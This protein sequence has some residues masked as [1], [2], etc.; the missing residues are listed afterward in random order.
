YTVVLCFM[1][2]KSHSQSLTVGFDLPS[3]VCVGERVAIQNTTNNAVQNTWEF[4]VENMIATPALSPVLTIAG[5]ETTTGITHI[6]DDGTWYG[7][8]V[9]RD[10]G[11]LFRLEYGH[12]LLNDPIIQEV[13]NET[14]LTNGSEQIALVE[15]GE[16]GYGVLINWNNP[17]VLLAQ[18]G[19][20]LENIP[21]ISEI[22]VSVP[23]NRPR[24][25][26]LVKDGQ[27]FI[28]LIGNTGANLTRLNFGTSMVNAPTDT[29][30][31]VSGS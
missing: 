21:A 23:I 26:E 30:I 15:D 24:G 18:F 31:S 6:S 27:N 17:K 29:N 14:I 9:S 19:S 20:S 4:C 10:N 25:V 3:S 22:S 1:A 11:K 12:S 5:G 13:G 7:F 8:V 16:N 2:F 28:A